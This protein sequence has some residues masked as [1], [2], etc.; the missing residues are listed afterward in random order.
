MVSQSRLPRPVLALLALFY[1]AATLL[2]ATLWMAAVRRTPVLPEVELGFGNSHLAAE[3]AEFVTN[4]MKNSP[5]EK[6]G[7]RAGDRILA[8]NGAPFEDADSM[9]REWSRHKPGDAVRLTVR[10]SGEPNP[11]LLTGVF[12]RRLSAAAES[13]LTEH[14]AKEVRNSYPVPFVAVGLAV[15][16]LRLEDPKVWLLALLF[17]AFASTQGFGGA[18][19]GVPSILR[20]AVRAYHALSIGMLGPLFYW[21]FAVFPARSPLDRR[22]PWLK[23]TAAAAGLF[24]A[25]PGLGAGELLVPAPVARLLGARLSARI[26]LWTVYTILILGL[27]SLG[28]NFFG[29]PDREARRKIRVVFWGTA[30]GLVPRLIE[31]AAQNLAG[32]R[33]PAWLST[34]ITLVA[35]LIPLSFAYA[36]VKHRVLDIPVLLQRS[37]RYLLVQRGF[38]VV[39]SLLSIGLTLLF[40]VSFTHYLRPAIAGSQPAGIALGAVF[41][42]A[43]LWGGSRVHRHVSGRIDRAFF[44]HAYDARVI[45]EDLAEKTRT[46]MDRAELA[47]LLKRHL[48][49][50]LKPRSLVV[51]L[52]DGDSRLVAASGGA[53]PELASIPAELPSAADGVPANSP[54][55]PLHPDCLVPMLDRG[56]QVAGLL[57][58]GP[59]LSE[60]PYSGEDRRLLATVAS[61]AGTA[62]ENIRM[63]EEIAARMEAERRQAREMEIAREVQLRLL[64]QAP[65]R[66]RTLHCA[67]RCIQARSVGGDC[68]DFLDLGPDRTG[69]VLADVSGKGVHAALL[70]ANLQAHLRSQS[71]IA[72]DDPV[73][74]LKEVNRLLWKSTAPQHFATLFFGIYDDN[75]R[76]LRYVNCGH[77]PPVWL[78]ADGTAD[79]LEATAT[80]V[81]AFEPWECSARCVEIAA[82]DL[83]AIF[84][85][86][87]TEE[88]REGEEFGDARLIEEL[89]GYRGLPVDEIV[90]AIFGSVQRF[91]GGAQS[92][93]LTLLV[94]GGKAIADP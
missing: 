75:S 37:A 9:R 56:G 35:F 34:G 61:Q 62:L 12:R 72:P 80:V 15:L 29:S 52:R 3:R 30:A 36:V 32:F 64:P 46:A 57:V 70:M 76:R 74:L 83:V 4:V 39:L 48:D 41:G 78:H 27:V 10:R 67:A 45:L 24:L 66:L 65:P 94:L 40:A 5:A 53:P 82:G 85:D 49:D 28:A 44:R 17:G 55:A 84:S 21:F 19:G 92:D 50:A 86:G 20:P 47:G 88:T 54:L 14:F 59:R 26:P 38:L 2:Y 42:T 13:G 77:N 18:M 93:D 73:R 8:V 79:R 60:E 11:I 89:R 58:L 33:S 7:L 90:T 51:Y 23:W 31:I 22:W 43:L 91:G 1:A 25:L 71:S 87:I 69:F 68:Y 63:A 16:F 6:A 81:G